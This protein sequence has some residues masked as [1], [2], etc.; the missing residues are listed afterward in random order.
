MEATMKTFVFAVGM[1]G[2]LLGATGA[3]AQDTASRG[4]VCLWAHNIDH[5]KIADP[6]TILFYMRDGKVWQN[7]LPV[8]CPA[9]KMHG[10]VMI[11]HDEE[12][13]GNAQ[14]IHVL[15]SG[16]VCRLGGFTQ[17]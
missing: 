3:E 10:F 16:E 7:N 11:G 4:Q 1:L 5:T 9:L 13:C 12:F 2:L 15:E 14:G 8:P 6:S 17:M